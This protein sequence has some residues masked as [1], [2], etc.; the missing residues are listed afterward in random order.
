MSKHGFFTVTGFQKFLEAYQNH[1]IFNFYE[2]NLSL[3]WA[4]FSG[5]PPFLLII[6]LI[7]VPR[8][9]SL[10]LLLSDL[11]PADLLHPSLHLFQEVHPDHRVPR[12]L[13]KLLPGA[14]LLGIYSSQAQFFTIPQV[15]YMFSPFL[16]EYDVILFVF[17]LYTSYSLYGQSSALFIIVICLFSCD[18]HVF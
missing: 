10:L 1:F 4:L 14:N 8:V 2:P 5:V 12:W 18:I 3:I 16:V 15:S 11:L 7:G 17:L 6:T 13:C 9:P